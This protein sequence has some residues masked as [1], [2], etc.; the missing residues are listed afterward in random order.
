[1]SRTTL[2]GSGQ[3]AAG[4]LNVNSEVPPMSTAPL[5]V[6][7]GRGAMVRGRELRPADPHPVSPSDDLA[8]HSLSILADASEA[9]LVDPRRELERTVLIAAVLHAGREAERA[10]HAWLSQTLSEYRGSHSAWDLRATSEQLRLA[11]ARFEAVVDDTALRLGRIVPG[12]SDEVVPV[13]LTEP[14]RAARRLLEERIGK[15]DGDR[16]PDRPAYDASA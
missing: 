2:V 6:L 7:G 1:M 15:A 11:L 3:G 10:M 5:A 14:H 8:P 16:S 9:R 4:P 12:P 13:R